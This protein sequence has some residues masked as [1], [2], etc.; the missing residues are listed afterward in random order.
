M[1]EKLGGRKF[2]ATSLTVVAGMVVMFIKGDIPPNFLNLLE[3]AIGAFV[4]GNVLS[5]V[6]GAFYK[7]APEA[8]A[9]GESQPEMVPDSQQAAPTPVPEAPAP[10]QASVTNEQL[11]AG[12]AEV[13]QKVEAVETSVTEISKATAVS[14]KVLNV[15]LERQ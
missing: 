15:L 5:N 1:F 14:Q 11:Y 13:F 12:L 4:G 10:T 7:P 8:S 6:A 2:L 3:V 9:A